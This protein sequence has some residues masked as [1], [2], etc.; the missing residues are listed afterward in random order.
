VFSDL[1][2][3]KFFSG[4]QVDSQK[5]GVW[6]GGVKATFNDWVDG[7]PATSKCMVIWYAKLHF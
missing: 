7:K 1:A 3:E 4:L 5:V 2:N 6:P